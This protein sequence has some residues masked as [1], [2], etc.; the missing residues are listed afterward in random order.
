MRPRRPVADAL[1]LSGVVIDVRTPR[2]LVDL[3]PI[4]LGAE[5]AS[6]RD[7][8]RL[9]WAYAEAHFG[10]NPGAASVV[11]LAVSRRFPVLI[12]SEVV[13]RLQGFNHASRPPSSIG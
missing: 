11:W 12:R 4:V 1:P 6:V 9:C 2:G 8:W 3:P 10:D 5:P 13:E 7:A